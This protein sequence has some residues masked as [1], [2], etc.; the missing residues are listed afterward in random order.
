MVVFVEVQF[1][2]AFEKTIVIILLFFIRYL[3]LTKILKMGIK[4][5][6]LRLIRV[7]HLLMFSPFCAFLKK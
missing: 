7:H 5:V 1:N 2:V 6:N 3:D 4:Y